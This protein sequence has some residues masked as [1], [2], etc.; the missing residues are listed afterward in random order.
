M[1]AEQERA[2]GVATARV[3][4]LRLFHATHAVGDH[5][6]ARLTYLE[7]FG[8]LAFLEG[9]HEGEDRDMSLIYVAD[10]M[11][12]AMAPRDRDADHKVFARY[13]SRYGEG[14]HSFA[15]TV[16]DTAEASASLRAQGCEIAT[17]YP[18][19]FLLHPRATGG[20]LLELC[21]VRIAQ[22]P[23]YQPGWNRD[24]AAA[25]IDRPRRLAFLCCVVPDPAP[26][27][28]FFTEL[29]DGTV[30]GD[31]PVTWPQ[32]GRC[33]TIDL[34]DLQLRVLSPL[35]GGSGPL[36]EY[37]GGR[38]SGVYALGW[39]V[40]DAD[41]AAAVMRGAGLA[42]T[43]VED[44]RIAHEVTFAGARHWLCRVGVEDIAGQAG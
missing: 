42:T 18:N 15:L 23:Y 31:E 26:T 2:A 16:P 7:A 37:L 36:G 10:Q 19:F 13:L 35:D 8:G 30:V 29:L 3:R 40:A 41:R 5:H 4:T 12:E 32:P 14:W 44:A 28:R 39:E 25:R 43:P 11:I 24:W 38:R 22:D 9:Y 21:D 33:V 34:A 27:V 17:D 20:V 6:A 1:T